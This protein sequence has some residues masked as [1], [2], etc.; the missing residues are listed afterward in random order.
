MVFL[1]SLNR[2]TSS[3]PVKIIKHSYNRKTLS[4]NLHNLLSHQVCLLI[5][6]LLTTKHGGC[7]DIPQLAQKV[8]PVPDTQEEPE[9]SHNIQLEPSYGLRG[10]KTLLPH[11]GHGSTVINHG[12]QGI[13][14][15]PNVLGD[16]KGLKL[17]HGHGTDDIY[18]N[19]FHGSNGAMQALVMETHKNIPNIHGSLSTGYGNRV[20]RCHT[21]LNDKYHGLVNDH[22][23]GLHKDMHIEKIG[24]YHGVSNRYFGMPG[25]HSH[26]FPE[27]G[28]LGSGHN[29][30]NAYNRGGHR[31][32]D[33]YESSVRS[34]KANDVEEIPR[35]DTMSYDNLRGQS[36]LSVYKTGMSASDYPPVLSNREHSATHYARGLHIDLLHGTTTLD[37]G[38]SDHVPN[39]VSLTG[40]ES[41]F[42][43]AQNGIPAKNIPG[44][45]H[46]IGNGNV[47]HG[48]S[49][50]QP[51]QQTPQDF[52]PVMGLIPNML[53]GVGLGLQ[54]HLYNDNTDGKLWTGNDLQTYDY[55]GGDFGYGIALSTYLP[56]YNSYSQHYII[57]YPSVNTVDG[58]SLRQFGMNGYSCVT[59]C[60]NLGLDGKLQLGL[61]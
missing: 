45:T 53:V 8:V 2:F 24:E 22:N 28:Y 3:A 40:A 1:L 41:D 38:D 51:Y 30:I 42:G 33:R 12:F 61:L 32:N 37:A 14:G 60:N 5:W 10:L 49:K 27:D 13:L 9:S 48:S 44:G 19:K 39:D 4:S 55:H 29:E 52:R 15:I 20:G 54:C 31:G 18:G 35:I 59:P 17:T 34:Y 58:Y 36:K 16:H 25:Y 46:M 57:P 56:W 21:K 43:G 23:F 26:E 11:Y 47:N 6:V 50:T 7:D